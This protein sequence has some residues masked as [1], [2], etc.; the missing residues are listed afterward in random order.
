MSELYLLRHAAAVP[1]EEGGQDRDRPL[2]SR[3]RRA[4]QAMAEWVA[5]HRLAPALVLCSTALR[6]RQTLELVAPSFA[7]PPRILFEDELYLATAAWL[8]SRFRQV[9]SE[10]PNVLLIGH[11]PGLHEL[12]LHISEVS[13][14][15]LMARLG[16]FPAGGLAVFSLGIE[17]SRLDRRLARLTQVVTPDE[18]MR[19]LG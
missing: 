10:V 7:R 9:A 15:P 12:A 18:L 16:G 4:I 3:G 6:A 17:W 13:G 1:Q 2:E 8:L 5:R 19:G 11:N 14:G